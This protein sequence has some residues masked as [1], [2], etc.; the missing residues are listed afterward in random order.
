MEEMVEPLAEAATT[1]EA[2]SR[3]SQTHSPPKMKAPRTTV[4][5]GK[6]EGMQFDN[7]IANKTAMRQKLGCQHNVTL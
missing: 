4:S 7:T 5:C 1:T 2:M 3:E 6:E